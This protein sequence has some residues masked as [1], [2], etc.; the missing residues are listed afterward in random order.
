MVGLRDQDMDDG[1]REF[2]QEVTLVLSG[3]QVKE[4]EKAVREREVTY[5]KILMDMILDE[6][7]EE[8]VYGFLDRCQDEPEI[9]C[10]LYISGKIRREV[11]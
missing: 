2:E 1:L 11:V 10:Q 3:S 5:E 4:M 7:A 9:V 6:V 8:H